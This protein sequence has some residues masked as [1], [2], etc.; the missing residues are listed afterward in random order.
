MSYC[1]KEVFSVAFHLI[2]C[3][4]NAELVECFL[5]HP[6]VDVNNGSAIHRSPFYSACVLER[7][8]I[9]KVLVQ[10]Q[11]VNVNEDFCVDVIIHL[12]STLEL[13]KFVM[14]VRKHD[15]K[16]E[17]KEWHFKNG[18]EDEDPIV[19]EHRKKAVNKLITDFNADRERTVTRLKMELGI[20]QRPVEKLFLMIKMFQNEDGFEEH[21]EIRRFFEMASQLP[22]ELQMIVANRV[23]YLDKLFIAENDL[24]QVTTWFQEI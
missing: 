22:L 12:D 21:N 20:L 10:D 1:E 17:V 13:I 24:I 19:S 14:C 3:Q 6:M 8:Q 16:V 9:I 5:K 7:R 4:R 15:L 11:R 23:Y 2:C 18:S